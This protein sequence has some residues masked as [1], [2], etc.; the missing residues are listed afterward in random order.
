MLIIKN[1]NIYS[2]NLD[3][4]E[5]RAEAVAADGEKIIYVGSNEGVKEYQTPEAKVI[6][7]KGKT[8][9]PGLCDAHVHATWS[10][11]AKYSC[12]LFYLSQNGE[13]KSIVEKIQE[14]LIKYI[15]ENPEKEMVKGCGWDYFDFMKELPHKK[16]LDV[17][18]SDKPVFLESY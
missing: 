17:I 7:A 12:S 15:E 13:K 5:I 2:V 4:S 14:K 10:G 9:L 6:D 16:M 1:A 18:C 3:G 8:V 11:S